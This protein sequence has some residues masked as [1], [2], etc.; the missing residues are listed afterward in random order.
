MVVL[1]IEEEKEFFFNQE[2]I[3]KSGEGIIGVIGDYVGRVKY[4]SVYV[5][6]LF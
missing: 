5:E 2:R 3:N 6:K 4:C 1:N